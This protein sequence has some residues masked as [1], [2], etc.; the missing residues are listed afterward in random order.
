[1]VPELGGSA[2]SGAE[3]DLVPS[4]DPIETCFDFAA[5]IKA[6]R[7]LFLGSEMVGDRDGD[8]EE[9]RDAVV[10][11]GT[12]AVLISSDS[13][14]FFLLVA[15][16]SDAELW[17]KDCDED[18]VFAGDD[19]CGGA[20]DTTG[21]FLLFLDCEPVSVGCFPLAAGSG[22]AAPSRGDDVA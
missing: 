20:D 10:E 13:F 5:S 21:A 1:M 15:G 14:C 6:R 22:E 19:D 18:D 4:S 3:A 7:L 16:G 11:E 8:G 2:T 9:V 17:D 12:S